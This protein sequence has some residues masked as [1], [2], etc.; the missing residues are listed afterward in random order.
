MQNFLASVVLLLILAL[1]GLYFHSQQQ[2][3]QV[4]ADRQALLQEVQALRKEVA[5]LNAKVA[6]LDESSVQGIVREA[7][8]A[9]LDGWE[10]LV[11][12]VEKEIQEARRAFE[13]DNPPKSDSP[14][15][16]SPDGTERI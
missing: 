1:G 4:H 11:N 9:I 14:R 12:T 5:Q 15:Y 10:S 3:Q 16:E 7:N 6:Q 13:N 8:N 2:L